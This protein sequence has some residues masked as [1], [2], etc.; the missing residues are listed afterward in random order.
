M[1]K[2]TTTEIYSSKQSNK[3]YKE[4]DVSNAPIRLR[5]ISITLT[6]G[7]KKVLV[8]SLTDGQY[9]YRSFPQL[10]QFF[11]QVEESYKTMN[12]WKWK[13]SA[14]KAVYPCSRTFI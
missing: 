8:T 13:T 3:K 6:T 5:F 11:W 4:L 7:E 12:F 1:E 9:P 10:H 2:E 14:G